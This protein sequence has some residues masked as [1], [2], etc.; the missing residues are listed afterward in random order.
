MQDASTERLSLGVDMRGAVERGEFVLHYQPI[1][2]LPDGALKSM[3]ALVRWNHPERGLISPLDFIPIAEKTGLMIPLGEFVVREACRQARAWQLARPD[4]DPIPVNVN[5]SGVQLQHPGLVAAVS[6][7]LEDSGLA[8][9]LLMLEITESVMARE[10][11]ATARRL[12][13]LK[14]LGVG[15]A[16]DDFG[17][18]YSSLSYLR[19]FPIEVVKI[20]KSFIDGIEDDMSA[21]ALANGIVQLAH[22]LKTRTVAEG[23]ETEAQMKRLIAMGCDRAQGFHFARPMGAREA[24][25][26]VVGR[27]ILSLWVGHVGPE[28]SVITSVVADFERLNPGLKV[29][30]VGGATE[31]RIQAALDSDDPPTAVASFE[32]DT[33]A[34]SRAVARLLDLT[35]FMARDGIS[36]TDFTDATLGYTGDD[37]G[38][39]ALPV[40]AD[41]YGLLYNRR[42]F[43]EAGLNG[44][45]R[46]IAELTQ[47]AKRLTVRNPDG[48]L[49]I[50]G[51][52]PTIGFYENSLA[53]LG[54]LF[55][56]H[57]QTDGRSSVATD[58]AWAKLL[59]W[60]KELVDWYGAEN[61]TAFHEQVG[62]E[63]S[64]NNAFQAEK[65]AMCLDGEWRV[66][67]I[68]I[69]AEE[70]DYG[71]AP[72]PVDET[73]AELYGSGYINGSVIGIPLNAR[74][75]EEAWT[76]VKYLATD[77]AALAKLSNGLRNVPST[78]ASLH[79]SA[80]VPDDR[81][82][83]FLDIFGHEQSAAAPLTP[84]GSEYQGMFD[85]LGVSWQRGQVKDLDAALKRLDRAID[86]KIRAAQLEVGETRAA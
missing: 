74:H 12:R 25:E 86:D 9:D 79:S 6:L 2:S 65:L 42:L 71:T 38:R 34:S 26:Y 8:P 53:T 55:G 50:V 5:L 1:V 52:D 61:L 4:Q 3:E 49:K 46:T 32:S 20:A 82:A 70:L 27:S 24:T 81:F 59:R 14:G 47:M 83:V 54:H 56:A 36:D 22:S 80:L 37:R 11:E 84:I 13:Q 73:R 43:R 30:V 28:L 67:F 23:V 44:P 15:L 68:A 45:P 77:E 35:P 69:E 62:D 7:A 57:W 76:L 31:E 60:Q 40:L 78:R 51:F 75:R 21:Q 48:S 58:P 18:G 39:W 63:F 10:T 16:I 66:A 19:R 64:P 33:F 85:E 72:L 41:A 29:E 17:T